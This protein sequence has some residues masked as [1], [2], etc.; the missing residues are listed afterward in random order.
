[1]FIDLSCVFPVFLQSEDTCWPVSGCSG[2]RHPVRL[3][4][5][6][7]FFYD[8]FE[9]CLSFLCGLKG[10]F[11]FQLRVGS[12]LVRFVRWM[13]RDKRP[14]VSLGSAAACIYFVQ[15]DVPTS[16]LLFPLSLNS[17]LADTQFHSFQF[18]ILLRILS[19]MFLLILQSL[20]WP[21]LTVHPVISCYLALFHT[22]SALT[23]CLLSVFHV[24]ATWK[25]IQ[26]HLLVM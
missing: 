13:S 5:D 2:W 1:M 14:L 8:K 10:V 18:V 15:R 24:M 19:E 6:H 3:L 25:V 22:E 21:H 4:N 26:I 12:S 16:K 23:M 7:L 17:F 11:S 20:R 9:S